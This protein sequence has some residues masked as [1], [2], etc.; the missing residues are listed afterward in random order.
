MRTTF[1]STTLAG[2]WIYG[3]ITTKGTKHTK[4]TFLKGN[5]PRASSTSPHKLFPLKMQ[6]FVLF[7]CFVVDSL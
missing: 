6:F 7:V 5:S 3:E 2:S 1:S 4:K